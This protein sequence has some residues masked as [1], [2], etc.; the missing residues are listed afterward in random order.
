M[1]ASGVSELVEHEANGLLADSDVELAAH[2]ERL[3]R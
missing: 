2:I 1:R 3:D